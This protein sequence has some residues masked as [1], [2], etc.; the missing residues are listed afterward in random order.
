M[1]DLRDNELSEWHPDRWLESGVDAEN[2]EI[3]HT[4]LLTNLLDDSDFVGALKGRGYDGATF[5][6]GTPTGGQSKTYAVW[7]PEQIKSST[8]NK[9][10]FDPDDAN[11]NKAKTKESTDG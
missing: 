11:I 10:D 7:N 2:L 4:G 1:Q 6:E 5:S 8:G 9:G 3:T